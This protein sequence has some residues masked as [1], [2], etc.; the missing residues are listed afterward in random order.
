MGQFWMDTFKALSDDEDITF[1][2][3]FLDKS[4]VQ[5]CFIELIQVSGK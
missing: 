2:G 1:C 5:F 3:D 4:L